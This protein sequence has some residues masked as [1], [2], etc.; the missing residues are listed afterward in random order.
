MQAPAASLERARRP[1]AMRMAGEIIRHP[2]TH[3][4]TIHPPTTRRPT[5]HPQTIRHRSRT[6]TRGAATTRGARG[7]SRGATHRPTT[8]PPTTHPPTIHPPTTHPPT[9]RRPTIHPAHHPRSRTTSG[10]TRPQVR[11]Q[12][13]PVLIISCS[14]RSCPVVA[15]IACK[16]QGCFF[17]LLG[18]R[19]VLCVLPSVLVCLLPVFGRLSPRVPCPER[20]LDPLL[21]CW[22]VCIR[23]RSC[24]VHQFLPD[25]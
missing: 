3:P 2:T 25:G 18:A 14:K 1:A 24:C 17:F 19:I 22:T 8:H 16:A 13:C 20:S 11:T 23:L 21:T 5:T 7:I 12:P 4:P 9:T 15:C 6:P 10:A